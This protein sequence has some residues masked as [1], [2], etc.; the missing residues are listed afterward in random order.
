MSSITSS[1]SRATTAT[2][3]SN[4][5]SNLSDWS[6][7]VQ[8]SSLLTG[9]IDE[10]RPGG[11]V[12]VTTKRGQIRADCNI[13]LS[14]G[15][16]VQMRI[17]TSAGK[18]IKATIVTSLESEALS[19]GSRTL[20]KPSFVNYIKNIFSPRGGGVGE[21]ALE[22][23]FSYISP[24]LKVLEY[25]HIKPGDKIQVAI[26]SHENLE[27]K[28]HIINGSIILNE[29]SVLLVNTEI[30]IMNIYAKSSLEAGSK[31]LINILQVPD[32]SQSDTIKKLV[33]DLMGN[34]AENI[35]LLKR[36]LQVNNSISSR[37]GYQNLMKLFRASHDNATLA[38]IFHQ[39]D[40]VP[41][42]EVSDWIEEDIVKP[43]NT[44][45]KN[46]RLVF[47]LDNIEEIRRI[48][49]ESHIIPSGRANEIH[50]SIPS[51]D[52]TCIVNVKKD[53]QLVHFSLDF[54]HSIFGAMTLSGIVEMN[55]TNHIATF[56]MLVKHDKELPNMLQ[57]NLKSIFED[58]IVTSNI[59][60]KLSFELA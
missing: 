16:E 8:N 50:I 55:E 24:N 32:K 56:K 4:N 20:A 15:D 48:L 1:R 36:M 30:G 53:K 26:L 40:E 11:N 43:F 46:H 27:G 45:S 12:I 3:N 33:G 44:V 37:T 7:K 13:Q 29:N 42:S 25:G 14:E 9:T 19:S 49:A 34:I 22:A 47:L 39:T 5:I 38:R 52:E 21:N 18:I 28:S 60:G 41:A 54:T 59:K 31:I 2:T 10:V 6:N 57:S 35:E 17:I 23:S 58:H 51:S